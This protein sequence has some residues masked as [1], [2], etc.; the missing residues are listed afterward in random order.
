MEDTGSVLYDLVYIRCQLKR[1]NV[2]DYVKATSLLSGSGEPL[3]EHEKFAFR[4]TKK[5][6]TF[7]KLAIWI[8]IGD[9]SFFDQRVL[10]SPVQVILETSAL[11]VI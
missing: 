10:H 1:R 2:G 7:S 6:K 5:C 4:V 9:T 3:E 11:H 8:R